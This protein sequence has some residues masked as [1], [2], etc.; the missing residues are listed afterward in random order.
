MD[1][2]EITNIPEMDFDIVKLPQ[3][4]TKNTVSS[5]SGGVALLSENESVVIETAT[6]SGTP[7]GIVSVPVSITSNPGIAGAQLDISFDKGLTLKNISKGDVLSAGTFNP[8]VS[9]GK[10]Q[11]YYDQANVTNTGVLFTLEFEVNAD[12]KNGDAYAIAV[13]V[14]DGITA[15]LSDYDSNPVN[16][17]FKPGE[18]QINETADNAVI[19]TVSRNGSTVTANVVCANGNASVFCGV[20][21][22]SG[23]MIAV[24][25][26]QVTS[27]SN[28]QFQFDGQQFDY[29]K[30]FIV[31]SN[32]C[33]LCEAKRT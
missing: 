7:G 2:I 14:T 4:V 32:F 11:W 5:Q 19:N 15:N 9:A 8:D 27:E 25:S 6:V 26:V 1:G 20:Y 22:N 29:A 16:A 3:Y 28:Y 24:R 30:V 13:N 18:I 21:N 23:K 31:D 10:V 12:A 33:P 17:E